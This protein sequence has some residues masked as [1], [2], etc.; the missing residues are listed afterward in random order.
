MLHSVDAAGVEPEP[1]LF[2][3]R[4]RRAIFPANSK[5]AKGLGQNSLS[6]SCLKIPQESSPVLEECWRRRDR[7]PGADVRVYAGSVE[8]GSAF[9]CLAPGQSRELQN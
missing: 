1:V 6:S 5:R 7:C 9:G 4:R 3:K 8:R 2:E